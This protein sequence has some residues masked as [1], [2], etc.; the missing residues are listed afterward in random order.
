M[1]D[2]EKIINLIEEK[3]KEH[4]EQ[5]NCTNYDMAQDELNKDVSNAFDYAYD[6]GRYEVLNELLNDIKEMK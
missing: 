6:C 3:I 2:K 5:G 1:I 4:E